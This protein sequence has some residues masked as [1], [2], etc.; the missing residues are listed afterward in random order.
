[1]APLGLK[2]ATPNPLGETPWPTARIWPLGRTVRAEIKERL[3]LA[4][5]S[6]MPALP[7]EESREPS[8]LRRNKQKRLPLAP[9]RILPSAW[10][11]SAP[12]TLVTVVP[13]P[14]GGM[15]V[16]GPPAPRV[17][18]GEPALWSREPQ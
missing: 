1:M 5:M 9:T 8:A 10:T 12:S 13:T 3:V 11:A 7:K 16:T 17:D 4:G 14:A 6:T 18:A 2:W 15:S